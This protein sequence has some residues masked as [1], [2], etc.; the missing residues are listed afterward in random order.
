MT[1]WTAWF[2]NQL[3]ASGDGFV[4]A[5]G[6]IDADLHKHLPPRPSYLGLW[7]PARHVWHV[8]EYERCL[9]VPSMKQ[10]LGGALPPDNDD[11][12]PDTDEAWR[13]AQERTFDELVAAFR[14]V[15]QEQIAMLDQLETVDWTAPRETLWGNKPLSMVVT[16]TYQHTFEHGDTLLRMGLWWRDMA[17]QEAQAKEG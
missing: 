5:F 10:W 14:A 11:L 15:R 8:T 7:P 3:Q 9:A 17:E 13:D 1:N 6:Q 4:W 2:R 12:W 16:K